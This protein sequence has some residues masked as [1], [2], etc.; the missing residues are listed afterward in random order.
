MKKIIRLTENDLVKLVKKVI[1]EQKLG[2]E[3]QGGETKVNSCET[4]LVE[5]ADNV[6]RITIQIDSNIKLPIIGK[7]S[8]PTETNT[9]KDGIIIGIRNAS[10]KL[11]SFLGSVLGGLNLQR[12]SSNIKNQD[13]TPLDSNQL[14]TVMA[15]LTKIR[16]GFISKYSEHFQGDS[17]TSDE[18]NRF[19]NVV[20]N[21]FTPEELN[22]LIKNIQALK[23]EL[24]NY[25]NSQFDSNGFTIKLPTVGNINLNRVNFNEKVYIMAWIGLK[26]S[27]DSGITNQWRP[28]LYNL[29]CN[30]LNRYITSGNLR[31]NGVIT[32]PSI[33]YLASIDSKLETALRKMA[34]PNTNS[35]FKGPISEIFNKYTIRYERILINVDTISPNRI[36]NSNQVQLT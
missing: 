36:G 9:A 3:S 16:D 11:S 34:S 15:P 2:G 10:E 27:G 23:I 30:A 32:I 12:M 26:G 35:S 19:I 33:Q 29:I 20:I 6:S 25:V 7:L 18:I 13:G 4:Q 28:I 17:P 8:A 31:D 22:I 14:N 24:E 21:N 5:V 1:K